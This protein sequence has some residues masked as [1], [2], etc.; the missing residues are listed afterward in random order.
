MADFAERFYAAAKRELAATDS[1][2]ERLRAARAT[3]ETGLA[4]R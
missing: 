4:S 2:L 3:P 1:R